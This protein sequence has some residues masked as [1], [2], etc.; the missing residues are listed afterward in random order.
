M[1][2]YYAT[3]FEHVNKKDFVLNVILTLAE[4]IQ[5]VSIII[6]KKFLCMY[7]CLCVLCSGETDASSVLKFRR[8][9]VCMSETTHL[10]ASFWIF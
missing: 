6:L 8:K 1:H 2:T 9:S 3:A 7:V 4:R 10:E 5:N